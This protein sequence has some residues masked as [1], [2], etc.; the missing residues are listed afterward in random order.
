MGIVSPHFSLPESLPGAKAPVKIW[1][2]LVGIDYAAQNQIRTVAALPHVH[3]VAI[4]PDVHAGNSVTV[5]S[6]IAMDNAVSPAA[7]GVDI[8]CG[9]MAVQLDATI[10]DLPADLAAIRSAWESV[11]PVGIAKHATKSEILKTDGFLRR[12]LK[13]LY[14]GFTQLRMDVSHLEKTSIRQCGTL[15]G[16]NHFIELCSDHTGTLWLMLHSGSRGIGKALAEQHIAAARTL[17]WNSDLPDRNLAIF[18]RRDE[19]G[20]EY[21]QWGDYLHDLYWA[22]RYAAFN[23]EVM[24]AALIAALRAHLPAFDCVHAIN[25]HHNYVSEERYDDLDLVITRKGAISAK[26]GELGIIPGSMGTGAYIVRGLGNSASYCSASHGAGRVMSRSQ[27]RN[28]FT[29]ADLEHQTRGVE[30][31]KDRGVVD[32]IPAAYKNLDEVIAYQRDLIE[33]VAKLE[34][35][36]CI[37][38]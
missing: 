2:P 14:A 15:G 13:K 27:A 24:M 36:V 28:L 5:G 18:L 35:L 34:T 23:R 32:E 9:M 25:C 1:S 6:V 33:V 10:T 16:G 37:K 31:R 11:V 8:G 12:D 19:H 7:V 21:P 30:C 38:G 17:E 29:L 26:E 3:G 20:H 4:M 22:Q